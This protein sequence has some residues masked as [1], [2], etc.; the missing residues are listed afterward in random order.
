MAFH[1]AKTI[2]LILDNA[3]YYKGDMIRE[4]LKTSKIELVFLPRYAPNLNLIERLW[5]FFK[6]TVL[7][8]KYYATFQEFKFACMEFF[9]KKNL[10]KY[11]KEL[12]SLLT[13]NFQI[14]S[15]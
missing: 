8:N 14:V 2:Y 13:E 9:K 10:A 15:A 11:K 4:Y 1:N 3:G 6:K 12:R 5:K 7:Y